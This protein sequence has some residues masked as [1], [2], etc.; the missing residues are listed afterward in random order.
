[1]ATTIT[2]SA[3][4]LTRK[5][6]SGSNILTSA[7]A[8][9]FYSNTYNYVGIVHFPGLNLTNKVITGIKL[10]VTAAEAGF[11][12][13][14]TK[15]VY[16]RQ[17]NY[18]AAAQ[19]SVSGAN[20]AGAALGTFT[21][22]FYGNTT[23]NTL[24]GTL[25]TNFAAYLAAGNNTI[26]LYNPSPS[27]SGQGYSYN[28]MQWTACQI[29]VTYEEAASVP[30][31]SPTSV[32]LGNAV[33]INTNRISTSATHTI[34]YSFGSASGTIATGVGAS[35]SWT[36]PVSLAA[37]I[38]SATSGICT[39]TCETYYGGVLTGT[40]TCQL[41]LT[42][43]SSVV[44]TI[45]SVTRTENVSGLAAQFA[46]FVQ[47]KSK[48]N[49]A[50]SAAGAHGSTITTYR[51]TL[52]GVTYTAASFTTAI[53]AFSGTKALSVT[54]TDSRGRTATTSVNITVVTYTPPS[55]SLFSA[56]RCNADGS[57]PQQDGTKIRVNI[58]ASAASVGAKNTMNCAVYYKLSSAS[59]WTISQYIT[60][61]AYA[62]Q[63][64]NL[65]LSQTFNALSSYDI[66]VAVSDYFTTGTPVE[67]V[68]SVGTKQVMQ[69]FYRD[70]TGVAFGKVAETPNV[71]EFAWKLMAP[72]AEIDTLQIKTYTSVAQLGL[73]V[74]A[75]TINECRNAMTNG[76]LLMAQA[77]DFPNSELPI[78]V[79]FG[80]L[81]IGRVAYSRSFC[82]FLGKAITD[83]THKQGLNT[84]G[85]AFTGTWY[86]LYDSS[87]VIPISGGGHGGTTVDTALANLNA[88]PLKV[89][90]TA[91][92]FNSI[93][94]SGYYGIKF[95]PTS[96]NGPSANWG[97]LIVMG[98]SHGGTMYQMYIGDIEY[99]IYK[100]IY[101]GSWGAWI[102]MGPNTISTTTPAV[103]PSIG[104]L[105]YFSVQKY[106]NIVT[107]SLRLTGAN[108][109][110]GTTNIGAMIPAGYR[111]TLGDVAV[112][113]Y[114]GND[115]N[116]VKG[117]VST[118]GAVNI[119]LSASG[120]NLN[121]VVSGSWIV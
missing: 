29:I 26:C 99:T 74:G 89:I 16:V 20:Y 97:T 69:D 3:S 45:S 5:A 118:A 36:P 64:T 96:Y 50:I 14:T 104:T 101:S 35:T 88:M 95:N 12:A 60:P 92:N 6:N 7:A 77:S 91:T 21:G 11:G 120:S 41:T 47:G 42:V 103:S 113:V 58:T 19:P 9:E 108:P 87:A 56:E 18:Q 63:Q 61:V 57:A 27:A 71:A 79:T 2:V 44:P 65:L 43:P 66:M 24:S 114:V 40:K 90:T 54:V 38:P 117:F 46:A 22:S 39:I 98:T 55:I 83:G 37:Q 52:D 31:T 84:A 73:T 59:T 76:S 30:T 86:R 81:L 110:S 72:D 25:L 62:V 115:S 17:S 1:M 107:F 94:A 8:Q 10:K 48:L 75:A 13:G 121:V 4:L 23:T 116:V 119:R 85:D 105:N 49:V 109:S 33:T 102:A 112:A 111:P 28:Y 82:L 70:G 15:T 32:A 67:Q 51:A 93:T 106:G 53:L 34:K 80:T 78:G 100:R 68:V